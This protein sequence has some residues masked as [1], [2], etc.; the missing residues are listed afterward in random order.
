MTDPALSVS[1]FQE[2]SVVDPDP[3]PN[4]FGPPGS[5]TV[6]LCTDP[7]LD[8]D[9]YFYSFVTFNSFLSLKTDVNEPSKWSS[10]IASH[11]EVTKLKGVGIEIKVS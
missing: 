7:D 3:D 11:K 2:T 9:I 10:K 4:V 8:P 5:V 1:G 6:I